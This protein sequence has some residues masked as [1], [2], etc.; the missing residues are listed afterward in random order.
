MHC[1][2]R[3]I[4]HFTGARTGCFEVFSDTKG[5]GEDSTADDF[6]FGVMWSEGDSKFEERV[7]VDFVHVEKEDDG[8]LEEE[9][10]VR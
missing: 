7:G 8:V 5:I 1:E 9:V 3:G 6:G 10:D 4:P 2:A